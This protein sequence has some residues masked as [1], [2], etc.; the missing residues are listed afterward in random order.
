MHSE[1]SER[2]VV[3]LG[4]D[5]FTKKSRGY[6]TTEGLGDLHELLIGPGNHAALASQE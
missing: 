3:G 6:G 1:H 2:E 4:E 5:A